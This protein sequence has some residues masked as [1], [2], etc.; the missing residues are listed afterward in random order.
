MSGNVEVSGTPPQALEAEQAV[1]GAVLLDN[2]A[3]DRIGD[4][5][6]PADFYAA[7]HGAIFAT[8][9][10]L[11]GAGK[12]A[13]VVTVYEAGGHDLPYLSQLA[14]GVAS[15]A[16]AHRWAAVVR[17]RS[18]ERALIREA[19]AVI[20][21]AGK[22]GREVA[23]KIDDAQARF[24]KLGERRLRRD[25]VAIGD[26]A[27]AFMDH[28]SDLAE[29]RER[30]IPTG[31]RSIDK[32]TAGGIRPGDLWVIGARPSMGKTALTLAMARNMSHK[33][34]TLFLSQEMPVMQLTMRHV[35]AMGSINL[36]DLRQPGNAPQS[37]W[38]GVAEGIEAVR[39]LNLVM[40]DQGSMTLLDVRR[41]VM[42]T[43]RQHGLDVVTIDYLQL[44]AGDGEN[45]N[46]E[47]DRISNGLK[48]LA[49]EF[50]V[51]VIL[52]SQL[53]RKADERSGP[54][55]MADL[56]DSGAIEAAADLIGMLY[57]D[58]VRN[59][60]PENKHHAQ[61]EVVKQRAGPPGTAHLWFNGEHQ[62]FSDW[63]AGESL[64]RRGVGK[65]ASYEGME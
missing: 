52:L 5:L 60:T 38:Q 61:L 41:K 42:A 65:R 22:P 14:N 7:Q 32:L 31:L 58:F 35:A 36:A 54:P 20:E 19:T 37:L 45:R 64:P 11:V 34:G 27:V 25:P 53:S 29:G 4:T 48:A 15:A 40:D 39:N 3:I 10:R 57:R 59:P 47:L 21:H 16:N 44:M 33:H 56:R 62:Q 6:A 24:A 43:K 18:I 46:Q 55:V 63:P 28:L 13:D 9:L 51:G 2:A 26:A 50:E 8:M 23:E 49:L 12:P 30:V 17:E 1:L